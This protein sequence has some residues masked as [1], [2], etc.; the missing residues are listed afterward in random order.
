[1]SS[2]TTLPRMKCSA[3]WSRTSSCRTR[4]SRALS[5]WRLRAGYW[6][7]RRGVLGKRLGDLACQPDLC[8]VLRDIEIDDF[9]SLMAE[10]DQGVEKLKS[11]SFDNEHVDGDGVMHVIVQ[12]RAPGWGGG[13]PAQKAIR[14]WNRFADED[15][16]RRYS[17]IELSAAFLRPSLAAWALSA[18]AFE[19]SNCGRRRRPAPR[20]R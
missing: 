12:K 6:P 13:V 11:C 16:D 18:P 9:S 2:L 1:M 14:P 15:R 7:L 5:R 10:D 4:A 19:R 8:R 17:A 3:P 20:R